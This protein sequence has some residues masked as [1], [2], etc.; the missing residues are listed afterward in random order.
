MS[1]DGAIKSNRSPGGHTDKGGRR[2]LIVEIGAAL[3]DGDP[4]TT[5]ALPGGFPFLIDDD[6]EEVVEP[7]LLFS[8]RRLP[9]QAPRPR[10][11]LEMFRDHG[12]DEAGIRYFKTGSIIVD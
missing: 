6:T 5:N 12:N 11:R 10:N 7:A 1:S 4:L 2:N 3:P 9:D 8:G